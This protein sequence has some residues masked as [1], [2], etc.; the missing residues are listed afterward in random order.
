MEKR[1][2]NQSNIYDNYFWPHEKCVK[3]NKLGEIYFKLLHRIAVT[4]KE[5]F[6]FGKAEDTKCPYCEMNDSIIHTL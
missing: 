5:L 4:K 3:I 1:P 6:L 2:A